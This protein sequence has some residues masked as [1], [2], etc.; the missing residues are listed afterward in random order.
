MFRQLS[1][2]TE[3]KHVDVD[4]ST[5]DRML[6]GVILRLESS[7]PKM[8]ALP[9][10]MFTTTLYGLEAISSMQLSRLS[11]YHNTYS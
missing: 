3:G 1:C 6:F 4:H 5:R 9:C 8:H 10:L 2:D 7:A 11:N